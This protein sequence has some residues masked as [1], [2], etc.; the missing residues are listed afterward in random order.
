[1]QDSPLASHPL[2]AIPVAV[3]DEGESDSEDDDLKPRG[4]SPW[5]RGAGGLGRGPLLWTG[6]S[7]RPGHWARDGRPA[8]RGG[9]SWS[10]GRPAGSF[11]V[12]V[13]R[14]TRGG[15]APLHLGP[16][17]A[18]WVVGRAGWRAEL[19]CLA[20]SGDRSCVS[21]TT[22][23][24]LARLGVEHQSLCPP[25]VGSWCLESH[26]SSPS[27]HYEGPSPAGA[28]VPSPVCH[29]FLGLTGM[30]NLGNSCYMNAALQALSNW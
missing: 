11:V 21:G 17:C 4:D 26:S 14:V 29:G 27:V 19:A 12:S 23:C 3:A 7:T 9:F 18:L 24:D 20:H 15:L 2:K 8:S 13:G 22:S 1:M 10:A 28:H 5:D 30:K 25:L 6:S 16:P